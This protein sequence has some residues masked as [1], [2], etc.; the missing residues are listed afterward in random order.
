[1][2]SQYQGSGGTSEWNGTYV[3]AGGQRIGLLSKLGGG[4]ARNFLARG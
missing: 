3:Y 1:V 4:A 2:I